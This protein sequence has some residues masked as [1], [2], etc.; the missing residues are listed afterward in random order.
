MSLDSS[1]PRAPYRRGRV[2]AALVVAAV[3]LTIVA[4]G[5]AEA[6]TKKPND[7]ADSLTEAAAVQAKADANTREYTGIVDGTNAYIAVVVSGKD[8]EV[9]I[10][11]GNALSAWPQGKIAKDGTF[12]AEA[13]AKGIK[14]AGTI[15]DSAASGTVSLGGSEHAFTAPL[16]TSPAGLYERL[17]AKD[18]SGKVVVSAT[19]LLADGTQRGAAAPASS[20][21]CSNIL[22]SAKAYL[23]EW[24]SNPNGAFAAEDLAGYYNQKRNFAN[25]G[26]GFASFAVN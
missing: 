9:Y 1:P 11:D 22:K 20:T 18:A 25:H 5:A 10:C 21:T 13:A 2:L 7:K 14:V 6:K 3:G 23:S 24:E 16:A 26:C 15:T 17:P 8:V 4:G 19:I 12:E